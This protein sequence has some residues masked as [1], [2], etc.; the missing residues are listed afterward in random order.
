MTQNKYLIVFAHPSHD[1]HNGYF[2]KKI[3]ELLDKDNKSYEVLDLYAQN[4]GACLLNEELYTMSRK[5]ISQENLSIQEK[6][7]SSDKLI[8]IYPTWWQNM[9]AIL[10]GFFDRIITGGFGF[11]YVN[12]LP[13]GLLKN[14]KAAIFTT[15][16]GPWIYEK[17]LIGAP[18]IKI[19]GKHILSFCGIKTKGFMLC[20]ATNLEANKNKIEKIALKTLNYLN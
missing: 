11:K 2:L 5:T 19:V 6:I 18:S 4:F 15:S 9:P 13:V 1:G 12:G 16:G 8:F 3:K 20:S 14:K 7:L 17:V 10:K